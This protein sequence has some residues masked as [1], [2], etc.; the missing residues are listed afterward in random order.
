MLPNLKWEI[1]RSACVSSQK[2]V[3]AI[4]AANWRVGKRNYWHVCKKKFCKHTR[5]TYDWWG[6]T[7]RRAVVKKPESSGGGGGEQKL[8]HQSR[9]HLR[10]PTQSTEASQSVQ[11]DEWFQPRMMSVLMES[12]S[13]FRSLINSVHTSSSSSSSAGSYSDVPRKSAPSQNNNNNTPIAP[14]VSI[15]DVCHRKIRLIGGAP[16]AFFGGLVA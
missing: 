14:K 5:R 8:M 7:A 12:N 9:R 2:Q 3:V 11:V 1:R 15:L 4:S 10:R 6:G 13:V 16:V